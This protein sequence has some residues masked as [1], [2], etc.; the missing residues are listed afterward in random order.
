MTKLLRKYNK[1]LI[2]VFGVFLMLTFLMSGPTNPFQSDP[3]KQTVGSIDGSNVR[4]EDLL[5][6]EGELAAL[7]VILPGLFDAMDIKDGV[8]WHLLVAEA[9]KNG[10]VGNEA[11]GA[12]YFE[13]KVRS[14]ADQAAQQQAMQSFIQRLQRGEQ[15]NFDEQEQVRIAEE[16]R[17]VIT[18]RWQAAA[19]Q[20]RLNE[21]QANLAWAKLA[22]VDRMVRTYRTAARMSDKRM[23]QAVRRVAD[24]TLADVLVIPA[25]AAIP[26]DYTPSDAELAS[27]FE[28][29]KAIK[30]GEGEMGFGYLQGKSVKVDYLVLLRAEMQKA[31]AL[32]ALALQRHW[33]LNRAR[34][35]GEFA[36]E[37]AAVEADLK[38]RTLGDIYAEADRAFKAR[39]RA[40]TRRLENAGDIKVLPPDWATLRPTFDQL[41]VA[42][43]D[44]VGA[45][46]KIAIPLPVQASETRWQELDR[47]ENLG[48]IGK[49]AVQAGAEPVAFPRLIAGVH[50]LDPKAGLG[51][52]VGVPYE[53]FLQ[54]GDGNRFYVMVTAVR[55]VAPPESLADVRARV[56]QDLREARAFADL[57]ARAAELRSLAA[58]GG[59]PKVAELF[60]GKPAKDGDPK[61]VFGASFSSERDDPRVDLVDPA[62]L[63]EAILGVTTSLGA[64][65]PPTP[66]NAD[67]RTVSAVLPRDRAIAIAQVT[68]SEP[69]TVETL[70]TLN[71]ANGAAFAE[72]ELSEVEADAAGP[73]SFEA[74]R[75]RMKWQRRGKDDERTSDAPTAKD[76][77]PRAPEP[78]A[79]PAGG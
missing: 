25:K 30:P 58:T 64:L 15:G 41:A 66:A 9:T 53:S 38:N 54:D 34:F 29:Y 19:G 73:F 68:G 1:W 62:P 3:R 18:R 36:A 21:S 31:I 47:L 52:Q 7:K 26:G 49:S 70:R 61:A 79:P 51:L 14:S 72:R 56:E 32:D 24:R 71:R 40:E 67:A 77:Q 60:A 6:S 23:V 46:L 50:E 43:R 55:E 63:R 5:T 10:L 35:P 75:A 16:L 44:G 11:Q 13:E 74:V 22:G 76:E 17:A 8:H 45:A 33:Q 42:I 69:V 2:A 39:L 59:V 37:K 48:L 57:R 4:M 28:K 12:A 20:S 65:T 78:S 27:Q